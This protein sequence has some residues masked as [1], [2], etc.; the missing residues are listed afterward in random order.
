MG[1]CDKVFCGGAKTSCAV[2]L[3]FETYTVRESSMRSLQLYA[4]RADNRPHRVSLGG[5]RAAGGTCVQEER[6]WE[7]LKVFSRALLLQV[8]KTQC[9]G[10]IPIGP[11]AEI[12]HEIARKIS[13]LH[14]KFLFPKFIIP[15]EIPSLRTLN[16]INNS[17]P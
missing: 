2:D 15:N 1:F 5:G 14:S 7:S 11:S 13:K 12:P 8:L 16:S 9:F 17:D 6:A 3:H 10:T 4:S